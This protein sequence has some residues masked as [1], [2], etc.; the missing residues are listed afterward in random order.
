M[1]SANLRHMTPNLVTFGLDH[2]S[3]AIEAFLVDRQSSGLS[4]HTIEFHRDSLKR[5]AQF[6]ESQAITRIDQI[7]ADTIRAFLLWLEQQGHKPGG[8]HARYRSLRAF[9]YWLETELGEDTYRAPIRKVKAPK[10]PK[11]VIEGVSLDDVQRMIEACKGN[12]F[13]ELRDKALLLFLLDTGARASEALDVDLADVNFPTG[14]VFIRK[15]KGN[16]SR[17]VYFGK[18]TRRALTAYLKARKDDNPALWVN[19][20]GERFTRYGLDKTL[21]LRAKQAGIANP[22]SAHDFRRAFA[23]NML[24][25]GCDVFTLQRLMGHSDLTILRRYLAQTEGDL[26]QAHQKFSPVEALKAKR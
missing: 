12:R 2:L 25:L 19:E 9:L 24:R 4:P 13:T 6:C 14:G 10:L 17:M 20:Q 23:L 26:Q 3:T 22:P 15:G 7:T 21:R 1:S 16:K 11:E 8:R 5:F 18:N